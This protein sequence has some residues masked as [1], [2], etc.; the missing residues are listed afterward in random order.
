[1]RN[2]ATAIAAMILSIG[3]AMNVAHAQ[4]DHHRIVIDNPP[5][6]T[7]NKIIKQKIP[8]TLIGTFVLFMSQSLYRIKTSR[9]DRRK[10]TKK[11]T[12]RSGKPK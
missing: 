3:A 10:H 5:R 12:Y 6:N 4:T 11:H 2:L 9:L 8:K 1:M 7:P